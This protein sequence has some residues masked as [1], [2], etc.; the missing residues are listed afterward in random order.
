MS[1]TT[2]TLSRLLPFSLSFG[3]AALT[4]LLLVEGRELLI[5]IALAVLIW[6]LIN[7]IVRGVAWVWPGEELPRWLGLTVA[8]CVMVLVFWGIGRLL[9]GSIAGVSQAAPT[10]QQNLDELIVR[11]A[12]MIG[13][14]DV[15]T[16]ADVFDK[17]NLQSMIGQFAESAAGIA[18][19]V[20]IIIVY[21]MFLLL[22]QQSFDRKL[23]ALLPNPER[24]SAVRKIITQV[25]VDVQTYLWIKTLMSILTGGISYIVLALVG[26]D[27]AAFWAFIIFL[28]NYI[29]TI[30][31]LIGIIF[32]ALLTI[33]QF[34]EFGPFLIVL[35]CLSGAQFTIGNV[36]EPRLMGSS[37][38]LSP[39]VMILSLALWGQIWG[40]VGMF[41]CVPIM[42]M[43][44]IVFAHFDGTR[45]IAIML[46]GN[47]RIDDYISKE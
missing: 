27:F 23:T 29:P 34:N 30:G 5:P 43:L 15:P 3:V 31:S 20:G 14:D 44:M 33:I 9:G 28:L 42:V 16:M 45:P 13:I 10:Y 1:D 19:R 4:L 41:L 17:I 35:G 46:S 37:L 7:A 38:N 39:L 26:V 24:E 6:Y 2:R 11:V 36:L 8:L 18:G 40:V 21:V 47:G 12:H 25:Q 32:P 22:E